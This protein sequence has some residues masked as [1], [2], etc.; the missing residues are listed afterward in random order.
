M[1][2]GAADTARGERT[3][4]QGRWRRGNRMKKS[5]RKTELEKRKKQKQRKGCNIERAGRVRV[6]VIRF[7]D[8]KRQETNA[9]KGIAKAFLC[10]KRREKGV[11]RANNQDLT[12]KNNRAGK[13]SRIENLAL[14]C[15]WGWLQKIR[16]QKRQRVERSSGETLWW[17]ETAARVLG[18]RTG[19]WGKAAANSSGLSR[20][21]VLVRFG[22]SKEHMGLM[23]SKQMTRAVNSIF[24]SRKI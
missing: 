3:F 8:L 10:H 23:R 16:G 22:E 14:H 13:C 15:E 6:G 20:K 4:L 7:Q 21:K 19:Y 24:G 17:E 5:Y 1:M 11:G 12:K 9:G 2:P 18:T